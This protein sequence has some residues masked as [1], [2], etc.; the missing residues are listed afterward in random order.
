MI[1]LCLW[2]IAAH[3]DSVSLPVLQLL[4]LQHRRRL[5][6]PPSFSCT[7]EPSWGSP[8]P[9]ASDLIDTWPDAPANASCGSLKFCLFFFVPLF[10]PLCIMPYFWNRMSISQDSQCAI[11]VFVLCR[12]T[13]LSNFAVPLCCYSNILPYCPRWCAV[14]DFVNYNA[15]KDE[16]RCWKWPRILSCTFSLCVPCWFMILIYALLQNECAQLSFYRWDH[17]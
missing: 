17:Q 2:T 6:W 12:F 3:T 11:F 7:A 8:A 9:L 14:V 5:C 13:E 16:G 4:H 15:V 10:S 1:V